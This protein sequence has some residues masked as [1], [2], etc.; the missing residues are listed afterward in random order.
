[1]HI[2]GTI[3]ETER[4]LAA[5]LEASGLLGDIVPPGFHIRVTLKNENG[6]KKHR[7]ASARSWTAEA[8]G[9][10]EI[11]FEPVPAAAHPPLEQAPSPRHETAPDS[12]EHMTRLLRALDEVERRPGY[13]FVALKRFRDIIM[14]AGAIRKETLS[15]AIERKIVMTGK[16]PNPKDARYPVTSIRLNR[17]APEVQ[18]ALRPEAARATAGFSP[19]PSSCLKGEPLSQ[20]VLRE[21]R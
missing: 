17:Q 20:T 7:D 2:N 10:M 5:K 8:G 19:L 13:Q 15:E 18:E 16:V 4:S 6:R 1:M 21:R 12:D 11:E 14:T 9:Y 3:E